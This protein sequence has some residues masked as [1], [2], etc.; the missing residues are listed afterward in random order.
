MGNGSLAKYR[1]VL[2]YINNKQSATV[3]ELSTVFFLSKSTVRRILTM[4]EQENLVVRFHGGA[5][6]LS[7]GWK[8]IVSR[9]IDQ[10]KEKALIGKE[11]ASMVRDEM[12]VIML[13]GTTVHSMCPYLKGRHLTVITTSIPVANDLLL[14]EHMKIILLG[15]LINPP[16]L[17]CRGSLT[18]TGLENLRSDLLFI[19]ATHIHP[20]RGLMTDDPEAVKTYRTSIDIA[21]KSVVLADSTKFKPGGV[22]VVARLDELDCIISS[23]VLSM[24]IQEELRRRNLCLRIAENNNMEEE[25]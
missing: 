24:E 8:S 5:S 22:S 18:V 7:I 1:D 13:G 3:N 17:E 2:D 23:P 15:G 20:E 19:G 25:L 14:E 9:K 6:A 4:M 21:D 12:T 11:A 16:E 10:L